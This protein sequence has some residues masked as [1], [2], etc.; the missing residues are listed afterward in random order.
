MSRTADMLA[1]I[2]R[3][4]GSEMARE[5]CTVLMRVIS[6]EMTMEAAAEELGISRQRLHELRDRM[7]AM[8]VESLEPQAPGRP[9]A[10]APDAKDQRIAEL[11]AEL[12]RAR[13]DL[14]CALIRAELNLAF[15][16]RLGSK[17]N[18]SEQSA[19]SDRAARR[20]RRRPR[21]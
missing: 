9:A 18:Y 3:Q 1:I 14:D 4:D 17:K 7:A 8:S 21:G 2:A 20:A 19:A 13:R 10:P 12:G 11:E 6:G 5:R 15:G 16:D